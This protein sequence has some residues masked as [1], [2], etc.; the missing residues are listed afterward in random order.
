MKKMLVLLSLSLISVVAADEPIDSPMMMQESVSPQSVIPTAE[1]P[2]VE[3]Q[4]SGKYPEIQRQESLPLGAIQ[5]AWDNASPGAGVYQVNFNPREI[6]RLVT[7]EYMTTSVVFPPWEKIEAIFI[8]DES[9]YQVTKVKPNILLI[10]PNEFVGIDSNITAFG[11]S[12]HAYSFYVRSEGYNSEN[13]SDLTVYVRV[14]APKYVKDKGQSLDL[15]ATVA[16]KTDYLDAIIFDP[17]NLDF[18]FSMSG[19]KSIAPERVFTD[20]TRTWFDYGK[21]MGSKT[22][23]SIY[24]VVD[25]TDTPVNVTRE[26]TKLVAQGVGSFTLKSGKKVTCV[27]PTDRKKY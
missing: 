15:D 12:G 16:E 3:A 5:H 9:S 19:N 18:S 25:G 14:A 10:R 2:D 4:V 17:A 20:G 1:N 8:G 26:G 11:E 21:K 22:L 13:V 6:I 23:P 7:R 24:L 27:Y